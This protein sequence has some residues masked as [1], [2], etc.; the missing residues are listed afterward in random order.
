MWVVTKHVKR[1]LT[2]LVIKEMQIK[3]RMAQINKPANTE[4]SGGWAAT[5]IHTLLVG[6]KNGLAT[7]ESR[8]PVSYNI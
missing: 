2:S 7:L 8:V 6:M 4:C 5:G 1:C 3:T